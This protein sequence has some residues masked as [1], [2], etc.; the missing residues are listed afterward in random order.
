[1]HHT[2]FP[3]TI[4]LIIGIPFLAIF[5]YFAY[6]D[7]KRTLANIEANHK[8]RMDLFDTLGIPSSFTINIPSPTI[9]PPNIIAPTFSKPQT[10]TSAQ[11]QSLQNI[12]GMQPLQWITSTTTTLN[13]PNPAED[14]LS[15]LLPLG[16]PKS[17]WIKYYIANISSIYPTWKETFLK[18]C[19]DN[20]IDIDENDLDSGLLLK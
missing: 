13:I 5:L 15:T 19:A 11:L 3:A 20:G 4:V 18:F 8:K 2:Y 7:H 6:K 17:S 9:S 10:L 16:L 14:L 12:L 1:M